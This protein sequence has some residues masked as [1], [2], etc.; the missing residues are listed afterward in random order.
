MKKTLFTSLLLFIFVGYS[1][2]QLAP[3]EKIKWYSL[4][5]AV[6]LSKKKPKKLFID[7]YTDWCGWCKKLDAVAFAN[8]VI[9]KYMNE[10]YYPVKLD[11]ET[12]DSINFNG[13]VYV[14][15]NP[16]GMRNPHDVAV[17]L[18]GGRM[19]YPSLV[20]LNDDL[21]KLE[22]IQSYL[23]P[24]YMEAI[25]KYYGSNAYKSQTQEEFFKTF[26]GEIK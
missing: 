26:K 10:H 25:L 16:T 12:K 22:L 20:I 8:P 13:Q 3:S 7:V 5:E 21:N 6:K 14:N 1:Q 2:A 4:E 24:Q 17:F 18:L 11:A 23:Q 9:I 19:G 15:R